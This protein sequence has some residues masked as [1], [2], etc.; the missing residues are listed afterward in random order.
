MK[1][2]FCLKAAGSAAGWLTLARGHRPTWKAVFANFQLSAPA[3]LHDPSDWLMEAQGGNGWGL[4]FH[5]WVKFGSAVSTCR[6]DPCLLWGTRHQPCLRWVEGTS[7]TDQ[8]W[9]WEDWSLWCSLSWNWSSG[10]CGRVPPSKSGRGYCWKNDGIITMDNRERCGTRQSKT[11]KA[12][13]TR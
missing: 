9:D 1:M 13:R 3:S 11:N 7:C 12:D 4:S 5:V 10:M 2:L 8:G 6:P